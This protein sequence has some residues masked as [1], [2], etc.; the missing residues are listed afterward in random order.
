MYSSEP[1]YFVHLK[2]IKLLKSPCLKLNYF[3]C[4]FRPCILN[5]GVL[6]GKFEK[7]TKGLLAFWAW[8]D[9]LFTPTSEVPI[10]KQHIITCHSRVLS[11][12]RYDEHP[13]SWITGC[14]S[15]T[16]PGLRAILGH[17]CARQEPGDK[18][19]SKFLYFMYRFVRSLILIITHHHRSSL[20]FILITVSKV[21]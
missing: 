1:P 21:I 9:I 13:V 18:W 10:L 14:F 8:L 4:H 15:N 17:L 12:R 6:V 5:P 7:N 3:V 2:L 11:P 19:L 16:P 20:S